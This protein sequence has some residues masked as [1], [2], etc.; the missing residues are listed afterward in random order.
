MNSC[1][2]C[3]HMVVSCMASVAERLD[4]EGVVVPQQVE[5]YRC[6]KAPLDTDPL[7]LITGDRREE[8]YRSCYWARIARFSH[9]GTPVPEDCAD[10][11]PL[12]RAGKIEGAGGVSL[13]ILG[14]QRAVPTVDPEGQ[15]GE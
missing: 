6:R 15:A 12:V 11:E 14:W 13:Q 5:S 8:E 9:L 2:N 7:H 10:W 3:A 4:D 1:H